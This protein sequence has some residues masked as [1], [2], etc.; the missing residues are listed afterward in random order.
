M[1]EEAAPYTLPDNGPRVT[2]ADIEGAVVD[3]IVQRI[4]GT[5][6]TIC[7]LV[8]RNGYTVVGHS[9]C[10]SPENFDAVLGA[11]IAREKAI[12][13]CWPLFGFALAE[14]LRG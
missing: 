12:E 1:T 10:V 5:T 13:Q 7:V 14:K 9:A 6:V 8:L 3:E 4:E 11:R 2:M